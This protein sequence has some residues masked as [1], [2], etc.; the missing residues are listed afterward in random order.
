MLAEG[1]KASGKSV[2]Q[3]H[4]GAKWHSRRWRLEVNVHRGDRMQK[5]D[6]IHNKQ[7]N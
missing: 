1:K 7:T 4:D 5:M 6:W 2:L 3:R